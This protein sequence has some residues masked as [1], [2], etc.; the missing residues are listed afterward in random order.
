VS[1]AAHGPRVGGLRP[2][3]RA[4][5]RASHRVVRTEAGVPLMPL[6]LARG[7]TVLALAV[8]GVLHWMQLL[9][10]AAAFRGWEAIG[11]GVLVVGGLLATARVRSPWLRRLAAAAVALAAFA[12]ALLAAGLPDEYLRPDRWG[13][14][15]G[16]VSRGLETLPGARVPF[17]G[18]DGWTRMVIAAGGTLLVVLGVLLA[19]WPRSGGRLGFRGPALVAFVALYAVPSIALIFDHEFLAGALLVI[20][21]VAFLRL[22][23]LR[24]RD[25]PAAGIAV[26][27]VALAGLL[28]A[29]ALDRDEPWWDYETWA[30]SSST[31]KTMAFSWNHDYGPLDW[32][33]DGRELLRVKAERPMYWKAQN[34]D[35]FDGESWT[36]SQNSS[37]PLKQYPGEPGDLS[38]ANRRRWL[39]PI[40]VSVRNLRSGEVVAAGAPL[41][42]TVLPRGAE[43]R[44]P[45][46]LVASGRSLRRGDL[47][48]AR[49]YAPEPP[50]S[51]LRVAGTGY[52]DWL[53]E[54]RLVRVPEPAA[55][56]PSGNLVRFPAFGDEE[57]DPDVVRGSGA[58][59]GEPA[60]DLVTGSSLSRAWGLAQELRARST[61]PYDFV[62]EVE[63]HLNSEAFT[64][65]E[66]P[67]PNGENLDG[68]LFDA[69]EGFCQQYS[70]AMA[71]LLRLGGVPARVS[72]GFTSGSRDAKT[73]EWVVRDLD[74]HSWVE[75]WFPGH[76]W[77]TFDPTPAAAPARS[78]P[79]DDVA[80]AAT[81]E[82][83]D[84][85]GLGLQGL[86]QARGAVAAQPS[87]EAEGFPWVT[88]G[89]GGAALALV[90][91][92]ALILRR[93]R[94]HRTPVAPG[95]AALAEL[96]R[97]L[98]RARR[99]LAPGTTLSALEARFGGSPD[100]AGYVRALREQRYRPTASGPTG[101]QRRALR[102]ELARGG[103][104][105][106]R[107][108]AWWALPP[109]RAR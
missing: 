104:A 92:A 14:V 81:T 103:G 40:E 44:A 60:L 90:L 12:L 51:Q 16:G 58:R 63:D 98:R 84:R 17:R 93:R 95:P 39:Q 62:Q 47:Y 99:S 15:A 22:E 87:Q 59:I 52:E 10:P 69:K 68:F 78:Q 67:P 36:E 21:V 66:T 9:E 86:G 35:F 31:S 106:G 19:F 100:A 55:F 26:G 70:G 64:Y 77:V 45:G 6:T 2:G 38:Q 8:F 107:L 11:I 25:A 83:G 24:L 20:L 42:S 105:T 76:G 53:D 23:R 32:P 57:S 97:A 108:R 89:L 71:L 27:V 79:L 41:S 101:S 18:L 73:K 109:R 37:A 34:L 88:V 80:A 33:R 46:N 50:A 30:L 3:G 96:E 48:R 102:S 5:A 29:P 43:F 82:S 54:Y 49:V 1:S 65:T 72:A 56:S 74:A 94:A 4:G 61:S 75:A 13:A 91:A 28:A 85:P 7:I